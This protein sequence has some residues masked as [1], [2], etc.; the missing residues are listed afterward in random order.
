M[1]ISI[2]RILLC[3]VQGMV[4]FHSIEGWIDVPLHLIACQ[5]RLVLIV[6]SLQYV[7]GSLTVLQA[8]VIKIDYSAVLLEWDHFEHH[9]PRTLLGYVVYYI[10]APY[11]NLTVY[12]GRDACGGD[13]WHVEDMAANMNNAI[14]TWLKPYTQYAY[15]V[16]T[17]TIATER[18]GAQSPIQ[19]FR[20]LPSCEYCT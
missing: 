16:K 3:G 17:Y 18:S 11:Q 12:D 1:T 13:G 2:S 6:M 19:Y 5:G 8:R 14:L 10:E 7:A 9:D 20:T 4:V 15:Y